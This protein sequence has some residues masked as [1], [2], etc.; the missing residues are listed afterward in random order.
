MS[1]TTS[2]DFDL[3]AALQARSTTD[4]R[5]RKRC[6]ECYRTCKPTSGKHGQH[7]GDY[8]CE[9]GHVF[10]DPVTGLTEQEAREKANG[11]G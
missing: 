10:D 2:D 3:Q 7:N 8:I 6:P 9:C 1:D 4:A 5:D 11:Q